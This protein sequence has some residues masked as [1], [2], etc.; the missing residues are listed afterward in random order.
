M[1]KINGEQNNSQFKIEEIEI[2]PDR[3]KFE[4]KLRRMNSKE[5]ISHYFDTINE[6]KIL[7]WENKLFESKL[8]SRD[9]KVI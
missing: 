6:T 1:I 8:P 3:K 7:G 2:N 5:D 9:F 4:N